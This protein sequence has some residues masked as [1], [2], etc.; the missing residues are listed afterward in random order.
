MS[1]SGFCLYTAEFRRTDPSRVHLRGP[2]ARLPLEQHRVPRDEVDLG[3]LRRIWVS[4]Q[5]IVHRRA[6]G[7]ECIKVKSHGVVDK[8][9]PVGRDA[10][11]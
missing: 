6:L 7:Q 11:S 4:M 5:Q 8:H 9:S 10:K 2:H 3:G 1:R